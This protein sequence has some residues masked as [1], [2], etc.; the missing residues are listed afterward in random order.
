MD[1]ILAP[2][3]E[4]YDGYNDIYGCVLAWPGSPPPCKTTATLMGE[5]QLALRRLGFYHACYFKGNSSRQHEEGDRETE[6]S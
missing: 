4:D 5:T 3:A 1:R 2:R 6:L